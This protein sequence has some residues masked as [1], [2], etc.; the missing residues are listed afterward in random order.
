MSRVYCMYIDG[1]FF[2]GFMTEQEVHLAEKLFQ[3]QF[4]YIV[5]S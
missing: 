2:N 5:I 3:V 4:I 1:W